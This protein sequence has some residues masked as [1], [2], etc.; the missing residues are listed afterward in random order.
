MF[1]K[2]C[3]NFWHGYHLFALIGPSTVS[4]PACPHAAL[5][6]GLVAVVF[7]LGE[8][9]TQTGQQA[10]CTPAGVEAGR[11]GRLSEASAFVVCTC[12]ILVCTCSSLS[13]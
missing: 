6:I 12:P 4:S 5:P 13:E 9:G 10:A 8:L 2:W 7:A 11:P 1:V 3:S